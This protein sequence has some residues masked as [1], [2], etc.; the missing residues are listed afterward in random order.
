MKEV[1]LRDGRLCRVGEQLDLFD[2]SIVKEDEPRFLLDRANLVYNWL[3]KNQG[4][5]EYEFQD[6][7][8]SS[9]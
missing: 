3:K 9:R 6:L 1:V 2:L 7:G 5:V 8:L 4:L